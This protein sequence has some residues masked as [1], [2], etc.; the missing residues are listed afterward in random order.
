MSMDTAIRH[1][2]DLAAL[3]ACPVSFT[4]LPETPG[5]SWLSGLL[6]RHASATHACLVS[7]PSLEAPG[8]PTRWPSW[9]AAAV[10]RYDANV[11]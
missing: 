8:E 7:L 1:P 3:P 6:A 10:F 4:C 2:R 9:M 11:W 5:Q